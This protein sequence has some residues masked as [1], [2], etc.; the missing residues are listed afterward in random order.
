MFW[1]K[2]K[3]PEHNIPHSQSL[4]FSTHSGCH[5]PHDTFFRCHGRNN[6]PRDIGYN[7]NWKCNV[8]NDVPG[9]VPA[10]TCP[11]GFQGKNKLS[12]NLIGRGCALY[13]ELKTR[14]AVFALSHKNGR[15]FCAYSPPYRCRSPPL[16]RFVRI[17]QRT[18][19]EENNGIQL[20]A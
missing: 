16:F 14:A 11:V 13:S 19:M 10:H 1:Q 17:H 8:R 15:F 12:M 7:I 5:A 9:H 4:F 18:E 6:T 3:L 20:R 2:S